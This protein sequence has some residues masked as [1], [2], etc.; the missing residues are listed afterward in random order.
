MNFY[1]PQILKNNPKNISN[2]S[3]NIIISTNY[4]KSFD[5]VNYEKTI[6]IINHINFI[7]GRGQ[8]IQL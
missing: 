5:G 7:N 3:I 6:L 2:I 1:S 4:N 8:F